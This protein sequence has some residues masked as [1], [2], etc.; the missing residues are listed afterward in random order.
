[1]PIKVALWQHPAMECEA[2]FD[3]CR[4]ICYGEL[5]AHF[6]SITILIHITRFHRRLLVVYTIVTLTL[7]LFFGTATLIVYSQFHLLLAC[8]V[9]F[10]EVDR[11]VS[12]FFAK[13][14]IARNLR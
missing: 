11:G 13:R 1:M 14:D 10:C 4:I 8:S 3:V 6:T 2:R 7:G 9:W 5:R 12:C